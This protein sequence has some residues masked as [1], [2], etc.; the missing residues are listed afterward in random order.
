M[1][2]KKYKKSSNGIS[3]DLRNGLSVGI[4]TGV[5]PW[6]ST[7]DL[8]SLSD[9]ID[10]GIPKRLKSIRVAKKRLKEAKSGRSAWVH[11]D[12]I[13]RRLVEIENAYGFIRQTLS[14]GYVRFQAPYLTMVALEAPASRGQYRVH[15]I[16][17]QFDSWAAIPGDSLR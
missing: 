12:I 4:T 5:E 1:G 6:Y 11:H 9:R 7:Y 15:P 14:N 8:L 16:L 10:R 3:N 2:K 17:L 13:Q